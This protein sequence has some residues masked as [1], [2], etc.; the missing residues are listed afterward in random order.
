[1][2]VTIGILAHVD[3]GKT[4]LSEQLLYR[5]GVT[6]TLGRVDNKDTVLDYAPVERERGIT[7]FAAQADFFHGGNHYFLL[8][9]PGH[10]DFQPE[11]ER[12]LAVLDCALLVVS[13]AGGP[14]LQTERLWRLLESRGIPAFLFLNKADAPGVDPEAFLSSLEDRLGAAFCNLSNGLT[15]EAREQIALTSETAMEGYLSGNWD[16]AH[17]L[18]AAAEAAAKRELFPAFIGSALT[19]DGLDALLNGLDA[20]APGCSAQDGPPA[21]LACQVRRDKQGERFVLGKVLAGTLRPRQSLGGGKIHELRRCQGGKQFPLEKA[22]TGELCALTGLPALRAG[23]KAVGDEIIRPPVSAP[24]LLARVEGNAPPAKLLEIFRVLEDEEPSL[25][26]RWNGGELHLALSGELVPEVLARIVKE[27]FGVEAAFGEPQAAYRETLAKPVRGCGHYEPLR[28]YAE[29]H[30]L[31]EPAPRGS[32]V[33]FVSRCPTDF[34]A[35]NWQR[36]IET[37]VLEREYPGPL[38]GS[39]LTDVRV[40]L[41]AGRAHEKHTEGGDFRQAVCRAIRQ[42]LFSGETVLLEPYCRFTV[43]AGPSLAGRL[44]TELTQLGAGLELPVHSGGA[45]RLTGRCPAAALL[46]YARNFPSNVRGQAEL[47]FSPDGY[48][49]CRN[50]DAVIAASGYDRERDIDNPAGSVFCSHGAGHTVSWRE[51]PALMHIQIPST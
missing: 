30:L 26:V 12:C 46:P 16:N 5:C 9:T 11:L 49:L 43:Q 6:R 37:H 13:C 22:E 7:V 45:V 41:L 21:F 1:M 19:G 28:H 40:V 50:P 32:G 33:T 10:N 51:A 2:N 42:G 34:L 48:E 8:D 39:P 17:C 47:V 29:V 31:L 25:A 3:A 38:T 4:T 15:E 20:L 24:P 14:L 44:Q 23:E 18:Y 27:R 35:R 36:L